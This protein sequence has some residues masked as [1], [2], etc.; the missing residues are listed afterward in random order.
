MWSECVPRES[1]C[2]LRYVFNGHVTLSSTQAETASRNRPDSMWK[3]SCCRKTISTKECTGSHKTAG[4]PPPRN[5]HSS[6]CVCVSHRWVEQCVCD[7]NSSRW[8]SL[9]CWLMAARFSF[10]F[11]TSFRPWA[12]NKVFLRNICITSFW[13]QFNEHNWPVWDL[14]VRK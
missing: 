4:R 2:L 10:I 1:V 13:A 9:W 6:V 8:T 7:S 5:S 3:P 11:P 14:V 12:E